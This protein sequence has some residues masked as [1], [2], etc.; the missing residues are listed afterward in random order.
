MTLAH[1]GD[2]PQHHLSLQR[3]CELLRLFEPQAKVGH[4]GLL[5]ALEAADL[6]LRR[7]PSLQLRY[8][9]HAP[10]QLRHQLTFSP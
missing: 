4:A 3:R 6:H 7:H 1:H 2:L 8:Q 9:L 10:Y 5:I